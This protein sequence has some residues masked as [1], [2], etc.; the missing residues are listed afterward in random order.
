MAG[1]GVYRTIA[2]L[3][4]RESLSAFRLRLLVGSSRHNIEKAEAS[5]IE[6]NGYSRKIIAELSK[7]DSLEDIERLLFWKTLP[8]MKWL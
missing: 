4:I 7:D 1:I 3:V 5:G 2:T 6:S 8:M